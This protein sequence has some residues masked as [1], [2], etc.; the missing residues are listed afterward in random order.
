MAL[1]HSRPR[2]RLHQHPAARRRRGTDAEPGPCTRASLTASAAPNSA[3]EYRRGCSQPSPG[4]RVDTAPSAVGPP[5]A[6]GHRAL[7][8]LQISSTHAHRLASLAASR[9]RDLFDPCVA[10]AVG[11]W[12]LRQCLDRFGS[13]LEGR[14]LLQH[15]PGLDQS[16]HPVALRGEGPSPHGMHQL[17][18]VG[19]QPNPTSSSG[20]TRHAL[21]PC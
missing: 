11:A 16:G 15:R 1:M 20:V 7:G 5:L 13:H 9:L 12:A 8:P 3:T 21:R 4:S 17:R 14:R 10:Y 19:S 6:G 18:A 2:P